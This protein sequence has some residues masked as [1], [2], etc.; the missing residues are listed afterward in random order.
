[1]PRP[2]P[3]SQ[4]RSF[5][6]KRDF[7]KINRWIEEEPIVKELANIANLDVKSRS[8][9]EMLGK[10]AWTLAE[11]PHWVKTFDHAPQAAYQREVVKPL[12]SL[13]ENL[14]RTFLKKEPSRSIR[15]LMQTKAR[16]LWEQISQ[17]GPIIRS[18]LLA[19]GGH[20]AI[21][22]I[23][24]NIFIIP[25]DESIPLR[26]CELTLKALHAFITQATMLLQGL[27]K[28]ESLHKEERLALRKVVN[29]LTTTF[30][31]HHKIDL[32]DSNPH[33]VALDFVHCALK[34]LRSRFVLPPGRNLINEEIASALASHHN[35][36]RLASL[37]IQITGTTLPK[38]H[39]RLA[40]FP[41]PG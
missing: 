12:L 18:R 2:K 19:D 26:L 34:S 24:P 36:S 27:D 10:V 22:E 40:L 35:S 39:K 23:L 11:Y 41:A 4:F 32:Q 38:A 20:D 13:A 17:L 37:K 16:N 9:K 3:N 33:T 1:M 25:S 8:A 14:R 7:K 5:S 30:F 21:A 31:C 15:L 29:R 28:L 6:L